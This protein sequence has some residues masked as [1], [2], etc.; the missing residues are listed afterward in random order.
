MGNYIIYTDSACDIK[1][2]LLN[3]WGVHY[4]E[5]TFTFGT[6][7]LHAGAAQVNA[8]PYCRY[9]AL[10]GGWMHIGLVFDSV[11]A[12]KLLAY[13]NGMN[14]GSSDDSKAL[15]E[16]WCTVPNGGSVLL[17]N[18]TGTSASAF[19]GSVDE[20]RISAVARSADWMKATHDTVMKPD[21]ASYSAVDVVNDGYAAWAGSMGIPGDPG[22]RHN[23]IAKGIRY[24]FDIAPAFGPDELGEP[25]IDIGPYQGGDIAVKLRALADGRDDVTYGVLAT[26]SLDDWTNATFVPYSDFT[27]GTLTPAKVEDPAP[28]QMFFKYKIDIQQ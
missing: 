8:A 2:R 1:P 3:E 7:N 18:M 6:T 25:I 22:Q 26:E 9:D 20:V 19:P 13:A 12:K 4:T 15:N 28:S 10:K 11:D 27:N 24:A 21:F 14:N 16:S 17:G 5:L 23:G